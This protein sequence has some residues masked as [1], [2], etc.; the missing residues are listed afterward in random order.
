MHTLVRLF[1]RV[2]PKVYSQVAMLAETPLTVFA[3][4]T[5][6]MSTLPASR[7]GASNVFYQNVFSDMLLQC[8]QLRELLMAFF[9]LKFLWIGLGTARIALDVKLQ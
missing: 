8:F 2:Y 6:P 9:A 1:P 7:F 3:L 5:F 4:V